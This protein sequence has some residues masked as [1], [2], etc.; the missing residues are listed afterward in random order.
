M[1]GHTLRNPIVNLIVIYQINVLNLFLFV[2]YL[3]GFMNECTLM[4]LLDTYVISD[5]YTFLLVSSIVCS[6]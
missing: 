6:I 5:K 1:L 3:M 4:V 2:L